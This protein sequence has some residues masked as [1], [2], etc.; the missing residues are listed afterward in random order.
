MITTLSLV[1]RLLCGVALFLYGMGVMGDGLK[2]V[3]GNKLESLLYKLTSNPLKGILLGAGVTAVIQSSSATTVMVVGFVNSGMMKVGQAIGIIM[4]ANIGTSITGWILCLSYIEGSSGIA[5][6]LSTATISAVVAIIGIVLK[7]FA[8]RNQSHYLGEIMLGFAVLMTGMQNMSAAVSPL[9]DSPAFIRTLTMFS[10]PVMG[11]LIGIAFTAVLQSASAS[12]GILQALSVTGGISFAT[13]LPITMGIGVGAAC[14]VLLSSLGANKNGKRTALIYLLNDVFGLV[15]WSTVFYTAN[16]IAGGFPFMSHVMNPFAIALLNTCFRVATILVLSPFIKLIEKLVFVLIKDSEA[17]IADQKDFDLLDERFL[18]YPAVAL[19]QSHEAINGMAKKTRKNIFR[20]M[21]LIHNYSEAKY[22]K[23]EAKEALIDKY[24]DKLGTYL[25][26]ASRGEMNRKQSIEAAQYLRCL[27]DFE[28]I[29]DHACGVAAVAREMEE[30]KISFSRAAQA[31]LTVM[32][33]AA[34]EIVNLAFHAFTEDDVEAAY[35]VE[36]IRQL[37]NAM[38]EEL[39]SRHI[40]RVQEG[41]CSVEQGFPYNDLITNLDRVAAHSSNIAIAV[42]EKETYTF[43]PHFYSKSIKEQSK[44]IYESAFDEYA[45]KYQLPS[46]F[47]IDQMAEKSAPVFDDVEETDLPENGKPKNRKEARAKLMKE[48]E[49]KKTQ[50]H[51]S[52]EV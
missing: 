51:E 45:A 18:K 24:E 38:A 8:K 12:I 4:G 16:A 50:N 30:K 15:I 47:E 5:A 39:K 44:D 34:E 14:P 23:V 27:S 20:A 43:D 22:A 37:I 41:V 46:L 40:S 49:D 36:P 33:T 35:K 1:L 31:E 28:R 29:S 17:D 25:M 11:I 32:E 2:K 10:N 48:L 9:K 13:A 26:S 52:E 21:N 19:E 42:I 6:L 7:N 3:A